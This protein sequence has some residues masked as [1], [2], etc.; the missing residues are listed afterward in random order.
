MEGRE[1]PPLPRGV[2]DGVKRKGK[3]VASLGAPSPVKK[4]TSPFSLEVL[5]S[6]SLLFKEPLLKDQNEEVIYALGVVYG[7]QALMGV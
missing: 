3:V 5:M 1:S 2:I 4:P 6:D 7:K